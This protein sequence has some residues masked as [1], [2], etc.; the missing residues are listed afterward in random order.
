MH[1]SV[2]SS[3]K[4]VDALTAGAVVSGEVR[5]SHSARWRPSRPRGRR[6]GPSTSF[7]PLPILLPLP[8]FPA[9]AACGTAAARGA[10][11]GGLCCRGG[12][13][14]QRRAGGAAGTTST[15]GVAA[16]WR[17]LLPP[18]QLQDTLGARAIAGGHDR[19]PAA[20]GD[21][22]QTVR[23]APFFLDLSARWFTPSPFLSLP[24][25]LY[26]HVLYAWEQGR[27]YHGSDVLLLFSYHST[28]S[29]YGFERRP[30]FPFVNCYNQIFISLDD[31]L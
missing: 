27:F 5:G 10:A 6:A 3:T 17:C 21:L 31:V 22:L 28:F 18:V 9:A 2:R 26:T 29:S 12:A 8:L 1:T 20:A 19:P 11:A 24:L 30:S 14:Q 7:L 16:P 23:V 25:P 13:A 15:A 4:G